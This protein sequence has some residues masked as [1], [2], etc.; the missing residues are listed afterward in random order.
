M[1]D[2]AK[3]QHPWLAERFVNDMDGQLREIGIGDVVV[4]WLTTTA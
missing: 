1:T 3:A 4:G 2:I